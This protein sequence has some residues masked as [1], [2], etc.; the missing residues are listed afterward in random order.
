M[1]QSKDVPLRMTFGI[2][3]Q[4]QVCLESDNGDHK[5]DT[6]VNIIKDLCVYNWLGRLRFYR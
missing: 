3:G 6:Q 1:E 2:V 4:S 5:R